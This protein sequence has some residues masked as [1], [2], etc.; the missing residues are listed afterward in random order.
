MAVSIEFNSKASVIDPLNNEV[1]SERTHAHLRRHS[2]PQVDK[3]AKDLACNSL[4]RGADQA[5]L[6]VRRMRVSTF[7]RLPMSPL[8]ICIL[9]VPPSAV[10]AR[11]RV[12]SS[13]FFAFPDSSLAIAGWLTPSALASCP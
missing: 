12:L 8:V 6:C 10:T 13:M 2:V 4:R 1:D 3:A 5:A 9:T 7:L 11:T